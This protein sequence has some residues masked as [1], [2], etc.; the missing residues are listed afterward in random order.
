MPVEF[1]PSSFNLER[2]KTNYLDFEVVFNNLDSIL[3]GV[4]ITIA[5]A[6]LAEVIGIVLGIVLAL[7][8]SSRS[9]VLSGPAQAYIGVFRGTPLL[10]QIT[11]I[12]FTTAA[13]G[14]RCEG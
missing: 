9:R 6:L 11:I 5:L 13:V 8:K 2:L 3:Q 14:I 4:L 7:L 12:Y 1:D 10:V